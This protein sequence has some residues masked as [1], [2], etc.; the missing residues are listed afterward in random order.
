[1]DEEKQGNMKFW[2]IDF[3]FTIIQG[4]EVYLKISLNVVPV[5]K[6]GWGYYLRKLE[7]H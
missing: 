2:V 3:L 1:M 7:G 5:I 6:I 4:F